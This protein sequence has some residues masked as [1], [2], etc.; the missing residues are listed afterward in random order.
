MSKEQNKEIVKRYF[1]EVLTA[2]NLAAIDELMRADLVFRI[3]TIPGG[4]RGIPAYKQFVQGLRA[5][6]PD[7]VFAIESQI[8]EDDRA[9]A[10]WTFKGTQR[11]EFLGV[12]PTNKSVTDY[13]IDI[14]HIA[15]GKI[16]DIWANENAYGLLTQLGAIRV[17]GAA[18][19]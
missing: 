5:A 12:A 2:G 11:G 18:G 9:A 16:T 1:D 13:G 3:P 7:A 19:S 14:F 4:V 15:G 6:F 8:A 10:R 17:N